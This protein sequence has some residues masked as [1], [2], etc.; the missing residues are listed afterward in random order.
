MRYIAILLGLLLMASTAW[1]WQLTSDPSPQDATQWRVTLDNGTTYQGETVNGTV[2]WDI[3][4]LEVGTYQGEVAFG[5]PEWILEAENS[6]E[7]SGMVW[8]TGTPF[9]LKRRSVSSVPSNMN[10]EE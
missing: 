1:G 2:A 9:V 8:S 10:L 4:N 7:R 5:A 6:T 3:T